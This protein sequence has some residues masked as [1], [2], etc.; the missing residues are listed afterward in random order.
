MAAL[1][2]VLVPSLL[3]IQAFG[4]PAPL[5]PITSQGA[6]TLVLGALLGLLRLATGSLWPGVALS[7]VIA[8][9]SL[10]AGAFPDRVGIAGFNAP[11]DTTPL[12]IMLPAVLSVALGVW[13]LLN[14]LE[15]EPEL[16]P[17]PPPQPEDDEEPGPL[18]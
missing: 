15:R 13:L 10:A 16:P 7:G 18:F 1:Q 12:A 5:A 11:G 9:L 2:I 17:I 6:R 3:V 8:A 14:Q 4:D